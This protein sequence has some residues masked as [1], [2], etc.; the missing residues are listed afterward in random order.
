LKRKEKGI[1]KKDVGFSSPTNL[2]RKIERAPIEGEG[3]KGHLKLR[4]LLKCKNK[5]EK[6][7]KIIIVLR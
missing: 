6:P 3:G 7:P 1:E 2:D 4:N 5:Y